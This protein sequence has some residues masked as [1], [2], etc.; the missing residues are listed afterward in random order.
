MVNWYDILL[1]LVGVFTY[2]TVTYILL[3]TYKETK[4]PSHALLSCTFILLIFAAIFRFITAFYAENT[5]LFTF[6]GSNVPFG[7]VNLFW[8]TSNTLLMLGEIFVFYAFV[9]VKLNE[10]HPL[11][12]VVSFIAG[13]AILA[14]ILPE[15]TTLT[16]S[17][18]GMWTAKYSAWTLVLIVPLLLI[19]VGSFL[20]PLITKLR[21]VKARSSRNQLL[22]QSIGLLI[23]VIW[24]FLAAFTSSTAIARI[25]PFLLPLGWLIW[26]FT[27]L[28]DPFNIMISNAKIEQILITTNKGLPVYY[29]DSGTGVATPAELAAG[30][31]EG[32]KTA[33]EQFRS[34]KSKLSNVVYKDQVIG[35]TSYGYLNAY[36]FGERFDKTFEIVLQYLLKDLQENQEFAL[37]IT[38]DFVDL[39]PDIG[40]KLREKVNEALR[41]VLII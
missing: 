33:L 24:A 20:W 11:I 27:L 35:I 18:E 7:I 9:Y 28:I 1:V 31:I 23:V 4:H 6:P 3:K 8:S 29:Y 40:L 13:A 22:L 17:S 21:K 14:F 5:T 34:S 38:P 19:F 37:K 16:R 30:L 12:N 2:S 41:R 36:V 25:R 32:V 26:S 15:Y 10:F 39:P